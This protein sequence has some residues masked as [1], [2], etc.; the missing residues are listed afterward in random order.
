MALG[1][2]IGPVDPLPMRCCKPILAILLLMLTAACSHFHVADVAM[3]PN[4]PP[5]PGFRAACASLPLPLNAFT[6][7]CK[8]VQGESVAVVQAKG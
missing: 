1:R 2:P 7:A 4:P 5:P 6:T 3:T 8:P